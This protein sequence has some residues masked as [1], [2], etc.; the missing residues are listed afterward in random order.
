MKK[1]SS[2]ELL[3]AEEHHCDIVMKPKETNHCTIPCP[4]NCV[5]NAW[6]SWSNCPLVSLTTARYHALAT[7]WSTPG[8]RGPTVL[9]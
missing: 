6:S 5:V 8:H 2:S 3:E 7:V 4:G 9:W 1:L